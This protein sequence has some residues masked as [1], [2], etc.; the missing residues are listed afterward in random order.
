MKQKADID[1]E[2]AALFRIDLHEVEDVIRHQF[3]SLHEEAGN[4]AV[5]L[6]LSSLGTFSARPTRLSKEV[7]TLLNS[8]DYYK[9]TGE[10]P[11][12]STLEGVEN[13]LSHLL[14]KQEKIKK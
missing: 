9:R 12:Y 10:S 5:S 6:E 8:I 14:N 13:D 1:R 2:V 3:K 4:D 7:E 11:R